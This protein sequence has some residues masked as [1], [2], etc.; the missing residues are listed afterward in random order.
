[1]MFKVKDIVTPEGDHKDVIFRIHSVRWD[2]YW[3]LA[4]IRSNEKRWL[5]TGTHIGK[6]YCGT[7]V[8]QFHLE[9]C[10]PYNPM[11]KFKKIKSFSM[12]E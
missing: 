9:E 3:S 10:V 11:C 6:R 12:T 7:W 2:Y 5:A 4:G 1:M 8:D